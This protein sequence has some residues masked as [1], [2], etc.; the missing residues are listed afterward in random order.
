MVESR[1]RDL[2][3]TV[4]LW[5]A[6]LWRS[7][8][9][10]AYPVMA[11][12]VPAIGTSNCAASDG[13]TK[14]G[15]DDTWQDSAAREHRMAWRIGID[16][17]GTFTD[18]ALVEEDT[19]PHRHR[20]IADHAARLRPGGDRRHP[21]GAGCQPDRS[22]RCLAAVARDNRRH[23]RAA[24]EQGRAGRLRRDARL[25]RH[26]RTAAFLA[27]RSLRPVAGRAGRAGAAALAV[28][29]HRA[30]RRAG[31]RRHAARRGRTFPR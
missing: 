9:A 1:S 11:G 21:S 5:T 4:R 24:G 25:P 18:V 27:R 22:G 20:Q 7:S 12:L 26:S 15:R 28:R 10:V 19:G 3:M 14:S 6:R 31:R 16:I 29:D 8:L 17:G 13:R 2:A 23:Q 30:D